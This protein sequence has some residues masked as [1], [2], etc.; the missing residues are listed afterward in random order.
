M[1]KRMFGVMA[2]SAA[3]ALSTGCMNRGANSMA[4]NCNPTTDLELTADYSRDAVGKSELTGSL[5]NRSLNRDY[6][7]VQLRVDFYDNEGSH[8]SSQ[9]LVVEDEVDAGEAEQ[10]SLAFVSPVGTERAAWSIS[11]AEED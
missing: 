4:K 10:F 7:N 5:F 2:L 1:I 11:C 3:L 6:E 9:V 8:V